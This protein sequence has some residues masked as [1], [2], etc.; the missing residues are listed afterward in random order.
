VR[1]SINIAVSRSETVQDILAVIIRSYHY[2]Y[3]YL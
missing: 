2:M 1:F 3:T